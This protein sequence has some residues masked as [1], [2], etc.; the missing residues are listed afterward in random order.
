MYC[1]GCGAKLADG[2]RFCV[3][4]GL[5]VG[6]PVA[7]A[8]AV[9]VSGE[10]GVQPNAQVGVGQ[11]T[12]FQAVDGSVSDAVD[13]ASTPGEKQTFKQFLMKR[14]NIGG[15]AVPMFAIIL[16][17]LIA[18]ASIATAAFLIYR[19]VAAGQVQEEQVQEVPVK[20]KKKVVRKQREA[21]EEESEEEDAVTKK[22]AEKR[23]QKSA[24]E[25]NDSQQD[26]RQQE[27][28]QDEQPVQQEEIESGD[29]D[30]GAEATTPVENTYDPASEVGAWTG[31][32]VQFGWPT[33][34]VKT[35]SYREITGDYGVCY[36]AQQH[37]LKLNIT[38]V[39]TASRT[40]SGTVSFLVHGHIGKLGSDES[41]D[42]GDAYIENVPFTSIS[43][44]GWRSG[45]AI[46]LY[47]GH[48]KSVQMTLRLKYGSSDDYSVWIRTVKEDFTGPYNLTYTWGQTDMYTITK[49]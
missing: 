14:H 6:A 47:S 12:Q 4:C 49:N 41:S 36:G 46:D 1:M 40:A 39:D 20:K 45:G 35:G 24:T 25:Q 18:T 30:I 42:P 37:P 15:R 29:P 33:G 7:G 22:K 16:A 11:A 44:D 13:A 31:T 17:A 34:A 23:I 10:T 32:M 8:A 2:A 43:I 28:A 21:E 27:Q 38:S 26:M 48:G 5:P 19:S 3:N 9:Q